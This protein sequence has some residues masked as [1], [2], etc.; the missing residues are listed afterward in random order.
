MPSRTSCRLISA[1]TS[2]PCATTHS[3]SR[4]DWKWSWVRTKRVLSR[5]LPV[6][7]NSCLCLTALSK[8]GID[9]GYVRNWGDKKHNF[10]VIVGKS[11]LSFGEGAEDRTPSLRRF[12]FV[13]T[14]DT[15]PKRRLYEV[16]HSQNLQMNQEITFLS[17]G[18][19]KLRE[20]QW[21]MSPKAT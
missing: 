16:L 14:L 11:M 1:S 20:L 17:D 6:S 4:S 8:V 10:E 2:K 12:G 7:G 21:E 18:D 5:V 3:R 9:G 13:Q 15:H 19:D